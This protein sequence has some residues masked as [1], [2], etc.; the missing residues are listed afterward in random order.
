MCLGWEDYSIETKHEPLKTYPD[1]DLVLDN[2]EGEHIVF[3]EVEIPEGVQVERRGFA[4]LLHANINPKWIKGVFEY[5]R[6]QHG[7]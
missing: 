3:L 7:E 6:I 1:Q 5:T 2:T 4:L